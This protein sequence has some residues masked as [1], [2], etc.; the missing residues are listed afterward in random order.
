MQKFQKTH[1]VDP[2]N[3]GSQANGQTT[4]G[5]TSRT[6]FIGPVRQRWRVAHVFWK[7]ENKIFLYYLS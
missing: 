7:F 3:N 1:W 6:D 2:E 4:H 5:Q